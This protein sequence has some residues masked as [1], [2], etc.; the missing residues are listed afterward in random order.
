MC[1]LT[2]LVGLSSFKVLAAMI[3]PLHGDGGVQL[4][5]LFLCGNPTQDPARLE[6]LRKPTWNHIYIYIYHAI[7]GQGPC[8]SRAPLFSEALEEGYGF[9]DR[10]HLRHR[11]VHWTLQVRE[12]AALWANCASIKGPTGEK[13]QPVGAEARPI[14]FDI[15]GREMGR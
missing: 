4:R 12:F 9:W 14:L 10:E 15:L 5:I 1:E 13:R 2:F 7:L 11:K 3:L 8:A 6:P